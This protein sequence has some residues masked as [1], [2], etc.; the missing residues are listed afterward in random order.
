MTVEVPSY[1]QGVASRI[2]FPVRVSD[3]VA[4]LRGNEEPDRVYVVSGHIDSRISDVLNYV[5]DA[6]GAND[7]YG[8][9]FIP[10]TILFSLPSSKGYSPCRH[11]R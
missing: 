3:V 4:T 7:E 1:V 5:D 2:P 6:P 11:G 8:L 9:H 10:L